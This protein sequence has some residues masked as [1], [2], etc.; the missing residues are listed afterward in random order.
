MRYEVEEIG[1]FLIVHVVG[2]MTAKD[3][4]GI[5]IDEINDYIA[6]GEINKFLFNLEKVENIDDDGIDVFINCLSLQNANVE[7]R[8]ILWAQSLDGNKIEKE[9][10]KQASQNLVDAESEE[11]K[12]SN[13]EE[14]I[15]NLGDVYKEEPNAPT[16]NC[17]I[18]VKDDNVYDKLYNSGVAGLMTIYR[19]RDD[20]TRDQGVLLAD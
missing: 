17:F 11:E 20:F 13:I 15:I 3:K 6:D 16:T 12:F 5:L 9:F 1:D 2:N 8:D 7:D 14:D 10:E 18:L 19:T 4:P